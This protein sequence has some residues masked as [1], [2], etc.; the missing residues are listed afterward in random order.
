MNG[1]KPLHSSMT[2]NSLALWWQNAPKKSY[3]RIM[4]SVF[5][6]YCTLGWVDFWLFYIFNKSTPE[7][8]YIPSK[9]TENSKQIC[10]DPVTSSSLVIIFWVMHYIRVQVW[11]SW[12]TK[13]AEFYADFKTINLPLWQ[14]APKKS[15]SRKKIYFTT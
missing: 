15:Y 6:L 2:T 8:C 4:I 3:S 7:I 1:W 12:L 13:Y 10:L 11:T 14:N 9:S 5:V